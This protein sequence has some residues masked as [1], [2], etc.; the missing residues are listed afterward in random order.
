MG[1]RSRLLLLG[2]HPIL[3]AALATQLAV[4]FVLACAACAAAITLWKET[5]AP[6]GIADDEVMLVHPPYFADGRRV[7]T[8]DVLRVLRAVDGVRGVSALNQVP[9][10]RNAWH[11][12][13]SITPFQSPRLMSSVYL[14]D[15]HALETLGARL[16]LGRGFGPDEF[17]AYGGDSSRL[18]DSPLPAIITASLA[19]QLY[20]DRDPL[21]L[22]MYVRGATP[23]RIIGVVEDLALPAGAHHPDHGNLGMLLPLKVANATDAHFLLRMPAAGQAQHVPVVKRAL[24]DA[25]PAWVAT[26]PTPL[27]SLRWE[28]LAAERQHLW[29]LSLAV[30]A[31]SCLT[32]FAFNV[33]G[34]WWIQ[35]H[36]QELSLRRALG[37]SQ[38]QVD[39]ELRLEYLVV[40][41]AGMLLG[42]AF[43]RLLATGA[44]GSLGNP[45]L[46]VIVGVA[47]LLMALV[48]LAIAWPLRATRSIPPH[49]VSRS[50]S[51]RL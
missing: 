25:F 27:S 50:P 15:E 42:F 28:S 20:P 18:P 8:T 5:T 26:T 49:L 14:A 1:M 17:H 3:V 13:I 45:S 38:R 19:R 2:R 30:A 12:G 9:Y 36:P 39:A 43:L 32:L 21:G 46:F 34:Q 7:P 33:A 35:Q 23:L 47:A 44:W 31:W 24:R 48:Q 10:G 40:A 29:L 4:G 16:V 6:R 37:A 41:C 11:A 51:V 22:P